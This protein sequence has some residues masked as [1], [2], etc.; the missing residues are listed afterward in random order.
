[1][2][3]SGPTLFDDN[4]LLLDLWRA[5]FDARKHKRNT[6]N[7]LRF[8]QNLEHNMYVLYKEVSEYR[9]ELSP[10]IC[11]IVDRPVKREIFAA[12]FRDRVIHHYIMLKLMPIFENQFIYDSY[13]CRVGKGTLFGIKRL[14]HFMRSCTENYTK[15]AY[16]MKLDLSGFFM[17]I[18]RKRLTGM[19]QDLVK[20][21]YTG[22]DKDLLLYLVEKVIMN[23]PTRGCIIKGGRSD[24]N[25]LPPNKSLFHAKEGCGIPIGNLTSQVFANYYLTGFDRYVKENLKMICYGRY[26]DDFFMV[27]QNISYLRVAADM[28]S[29]FLEKRM[30]VRLHPHK[31]YLQP[32][33]H[34]VMYLGALI[35]PWGIFPS[36]RL[37]KNF[38]V[39]LS[40]HDSESI[41]LLNVEEKFQ[42]QSGYNSYF[43]FHHHYHVYREFL[44]STNMPLL[45]VV[46]GG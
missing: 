23:D 3:E 17:S 11:F 10:S 5:Y 43:G 41:L 20:R 46:L 45:A 42:L 12:H 36:Q 32:C 35:T 14:E 37:R 4:G 9:Y 33:R 44:D 25:G 2:T 22:G 29:S 16:V 1:M 26:V 15:E 6:M 18:N 31:R 19:V 21:K 39:F 28:M 38:H 34:G 7:A 30:S 40:Q 13:S 24:W 27:H 8:E